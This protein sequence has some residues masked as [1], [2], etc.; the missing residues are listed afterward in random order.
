MKTKRVIAFILTLVLTLTACSSAFAA[1]YTQIMMVNLETKTYKWV[2]D[3]KES[4]ENMNFV[5]IQR[6]HTSTY[7][8]AL[9]D[10]YITLD[11]VP[12]EL[13]I[14]LYDDNGGTIGVP[15][16]LVEEYTSSG[17]HEKASTVTMYAPDGR[18]LNIAPSN[19]DAYKAVG[20]YTEPVITLYAYDGRQEVFLMSEAEAQMT[21]G[22]YKTPFV[23]L[24]A[25]DGRSERFPQNEVAAQKTV[26]WYDE[27]FVTMY[28]LDGRTAKFPKSEVSAQRKV[29]WYDSIEDVN[30]EKEKQW[31]AYQKEL[32]LSKKFYVGAR[33]AGSIISYEWYGTV[34]EISNGKVLVN[35][36]GFYDSYGFKIT[37]QFEIITLEYST[38]VYL[39]EPTWYNASEVFLA[40]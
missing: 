38:G 22:W 9:V 40:K 27:P 12:K 32:E 35:W 23:T 16:F 17:W 21:V 2:Y 24:Y 6:P 5:N 26:G 37:N 25:Y 34:K 39:N 18:T 3:Y 28:A 4:W 33:V 31:Q 7:Q 11:K 36:E 19:V 29:G 14:T 10:G 30:K 15:D 1:T 8:Q 13:Q 20:W